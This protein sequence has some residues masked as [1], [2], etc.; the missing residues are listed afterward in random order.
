[1]CAADQI[2][3]SSFPCGVGGGEM[4]LNMAFHPFYK[5]HRWLPPPSPIQNEITA[6]L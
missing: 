2:L 4:M 5:S 1:M 6:V 3:Y